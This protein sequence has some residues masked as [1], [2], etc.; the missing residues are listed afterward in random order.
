MQPRASARAAR[1]GIIAACFALGAWAAWPALAQA[2]NEHDHAIPA[3]VDD[4]QPPAFASRAI[5]LA[6]HITELVYAAGAGD[7]I[8][9]T[10]TSS[11]YPPQARRIPRIGDGLN[12]NVEHA[13]SLQPEVVIAWLA[14]GAAPTLAPALSTLDIPLIF[15]RPGKL[16]DIPAE[17]LRFGKLFNTQTPAMAMAQ[18]LTRRLD[19]L[20]ARYAGQK[21]VS[22]FIEVGTS[23]L[24][25]LGKSPMINDAL[26]LCGGVNVYANANIAAPQASVE[27]VLVKRPDVVITPARGEAAQ[28]EARL[29]WAAVHLP[30]AL[31]G[32]V[33]AVDPDKLF[34]PGP[35]LIDATEQ[36]CQQLELARQAPSGPD[37]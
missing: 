28:E 30:A 20:G 33:Y 25:T 5:T 37:R 3:P 16:S 35:R 10:V 12:I 24:Y 23:P 14:H 7:K 22:V 21:T 9:G 17:I 15:S 27:S 2:T 34:R 11:D 32:H 8:V 29:R 13:I 18:A 19:A 26:R 4:T 6:P 1:A 31:N 36:L